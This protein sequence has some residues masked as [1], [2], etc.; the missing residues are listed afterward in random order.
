MDVWAILEWT[1]V[2]SGIACVIFAA[3]EKIWTWPLGII[4]VGIFLAIF[5][6]AKLY[7]DM[8]LQVFFLA[9]GFYGWYQWL[10]GGSSKDE[11]PISRS[12]LNEWLIYIGIGIV[13]LLLIGYLF[14]TYTDADLAYW[15]AYTTAFSLVA[16]ILMARKKLANWL[17]WIAVDVVAIGIYFYKELYPTSFLYCIY[18][19]ICIWGYINWRKIYIEQQTEPVPSPLA[20]P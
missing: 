12:S 20:R 16:Q 3:K 9:S 17:I 10:Y 8:S 11:L 19:G 2:I 18:L 6:H 14:D 7:A 1:A 4:S 15:D 5:F 13:S